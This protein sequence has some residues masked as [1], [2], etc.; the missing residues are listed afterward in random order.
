MRLTDQTLLTQIAYS[1]RD[2][3]VRVE[4]TFKIKNQETLEIIAS[5]D[6][7][8]KVRCVAVQNLTNQAALIRLA[9]KE[10]NYLVSG[11][12]FHKIKNNQD[13]VI[14]IALKKPVAEIRA[15]A[16]QVVKEKWVKEKLALTDPD[17]HVR[18]NAIYGLDDDL[19]KKIAE[20]DASERVKK[21]AKRQL[22][23]RE[24]TRKE[25]AGLPP[26]KNNPNYEQRP[27][28]Y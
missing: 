9:Q 5:T 22:E 27:K 26:W 11:E 7:K 28:R 20:S 15:Q 12:I 24:K 25:F 23:I 19:I 10:A 4:A 13:A 8:W 6:A 17:E 1:D 18:K 3:G 14:D 16:I 21:F 2:T